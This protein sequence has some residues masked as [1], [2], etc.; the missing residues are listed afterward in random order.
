MKELRKFTWALKHR[1]QF[2]E[3]GREEGKHARQRE[4]LEQR[5]GVKALLWAWGVSWPFFV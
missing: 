1:E 3:M 4:E 2:K 5:S